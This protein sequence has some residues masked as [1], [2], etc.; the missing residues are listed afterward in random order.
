MSPNRR[1]VFCFLTMTVLLLPIQFINDDGQVLT[2]REPPLNQT[3][4]VNDSNSPLDVLSFLQQ[5]D[6]FKLIEFI[7]NIESNILF[8]RIDS[9]NINLNPSYQTGISPHFYNGP[10]SVE[11]TCKHVRFSYLCPANITTEK[12]K[13][14][15]WTLKINEQNLSEDSKQFLHQLQSKYNFYTDV[16][17]KIIQNAEDQKLFKKGKM[18]ILLYGNSHLRQI[19]EALQCIL[20]DIEYDILQHDTT[21]LIKTYLP[22]IQRLHPEPI[23]NFSYDNTFCFGIA[24]SA[25]PKWNNR[26]WNGLHLENIRGILQSELTDKNIKF[27]KSDNVYIELHDDTNLHYHF[28]HQEA[29]KSMYAYARNRLSKRLKESLNAS[30]DMA[31]DFDVIVFNVGNTPVYNLQNLKHD[32]YKLNHMNKPVILL[33]TFHNTSEL[34]EEFYEKHP[35]LIYVDLHKRIY[36]K[37][38]KNTKNDTLKYLLAGESVD[39]PKHFCQP[40]IV[41]HLSLALVELINLFSLTQ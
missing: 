29:V 4:V 12:G 31:L 40:G 39:A 8:E 25:R 14:N 22:K 35:N 28:V 34:N 3:N 7:R 5:Y 38:W 30:L 1:F 21:K 36:S 11:K 41:E 23:N 27:C 9:D 24:N 17:N 13:I 20:D 6:K 26:E 10:F 19:F 2:G 37:L 16:Y 18:N 15:E 32:L 33:S